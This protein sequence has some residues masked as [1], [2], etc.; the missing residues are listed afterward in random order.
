[1]DREEFEKLVLQVMT[2]EWHREPY[3]KV[4]QAFD[5][6]TAERIRCSR[7]GASVSSP[8]PQDTIVRAFIECGDCLEKQPDWQQRAETAKEWLRKIVEAYKDA[9]VGA[10]EYGAC[11]A[12]DAYIES[13]NE[14][15]EVRGT[16][17]PDIAY[18]QFLETSPTPSPKDKALEDIR[19]VRGSK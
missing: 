14:S 3:T 6:L 15:V 9:N 2:H 19:N 13:N 10:D 4:M 5:T 12:I 1:M 8:V 11:A 16:P 17:P 7:C 18:E